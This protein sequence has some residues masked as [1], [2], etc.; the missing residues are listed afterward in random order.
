MAWSRLVCRGWLGLCVGPGCASQWEDESLQNEGDVCFVD[1]GEVLE[2][3]VSVDCLG[4]GCTR[5]FENTCEATREG[6][7]ITVTS[8]FTWQDRPTGPCTA[9]CFTPTAVCQLPTPPDGTYAVVHGEQTSSLTV[10][11]I[12]PCDAL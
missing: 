1:R 11:T 2:V 7:T 6:E 12:E 5:N 4:G 3:A 10:P 8:E 9:D